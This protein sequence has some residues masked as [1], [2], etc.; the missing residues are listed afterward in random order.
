MY[1]WEIAKQVGTHFERHW[2][3]RQAEREDAR[4]RLLRAIG[5][6]VV[7]P[8]MRM[9]LAMRVARRMLERTESHQRAHRSARDLD[10]ILAEREAGRPLPDDLLAQARQHLSEAESSV[11]T[12]EAW[13]E[14]CELES[15]QRERALLTAAVAFGDAT[16]GWKT[17]MSAAL[18]HAALC[19]WFEVYSQA[20]LDSG[21][22]AHHV[23]YMRE[24]ATI[25]LELLAVIA[26]RQ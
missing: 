18:E 9:S 7:P 26:A 5:D 22:L 24:A 10:A 15:A 2:K 14:G 13:G 23:G 6:D 17:V 21:A 12:W 4:D 25:L 19:E 1:P 16:D 8:K 3:E 20:L 11:K